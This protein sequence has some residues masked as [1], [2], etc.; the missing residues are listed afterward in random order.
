MITCGHNKALYRR[1][2][3]ATPAHSKYLHG[4]YYGSKSGAN[5]VAAVAQFKNSIQRDQRWLLYGGLD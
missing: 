4:L 5:V 3:A 1:D 2:K